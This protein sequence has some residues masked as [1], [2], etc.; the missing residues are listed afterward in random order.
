[1]QAHKKFSP[2]KESFT[3]EIPILLQGFTREKIDIIWGAKNH[4]N[5]YTTWGA[6]PILIH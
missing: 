6:F 2:I 1:M 3:R 5:L 4:V